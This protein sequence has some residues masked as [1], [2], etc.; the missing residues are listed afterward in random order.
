MPN[1]MMQT[2]QQ[3]NVLG[4]MP[5]QYQMPVQ[6]NMY[7]PQLELFKMKARQLAQQG[8]VLPNCVTDQYALM[9]LT[10][11]DLSHVHEFYEVLDA[12]IDR[13]KVDQKNRLSKTQGLRQIAFQMIKDRISE[14]YSAK[15]AKKNN[16]SLS[17]LKV[18][19][20]GSMATGLA[21]DSSDLDILVHGFIHPES[22]RFQNLSRDELVYE[23]QMLHS[24]LS[25]LYAIQSNQLIET[26]SVPLIKLQMNLSAICS[27]HPDLNIKPESLDDETKVLH[28]DITLDEP[29][30]P[31]EQQH[32]GI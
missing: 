3:M 13:I 23:L 21:I 18:E 28:I 11:Q 26:A 31:N 1:S 24:G 12:Q 15:Q 27:K 22:P 9:M 14:L 17:N 16:R 2:N 29:K 5:N 6:P 10:Q 20:Y 7:A 25:E 30:K 8:Y 32:L 4:Q 19:I